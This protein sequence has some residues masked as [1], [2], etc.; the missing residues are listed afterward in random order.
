MCIRDRWGRFL[1]HIIGKVA[2]ARIHQAVD[3]LWIFKLNGFINLLLSGLIFSDECQIFSAL[4]D[5]GHIALLHHIQ[6]GAVVHFRDLLFQ[7]LREKQRKMCIRDSYQ[8]VSRA[9]D[10]LFAA[11]KELESYRSMS[12]GNIRIGSSERC[13]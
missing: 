6:E 8:Y 3:Q 10:Q 11:E 9:C 4:L 2:H 12:E 1:H 13:V 7:H 5:L